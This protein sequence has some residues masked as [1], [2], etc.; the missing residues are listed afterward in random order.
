MDNL[1][2]VYLLQG[3]PLT[4]VDKTIYDDIGEWF[5]KGLMDIKP[6][7]MNETEK[8]MFAFA[9]IRGK[10]LDPIL[11]D[12]SALPVTDVERETLVRFSEQYA[13]NY[14][15]GILLI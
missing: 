1:R 6:E 2:I 15:V 5:P 7:D 12:I 10:Q 3:I 14:S 11:F 4:E 13:E 8:I 9:V